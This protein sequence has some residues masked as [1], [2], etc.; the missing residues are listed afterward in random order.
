M[1]L[2][3]VDF[4]SKRIGLATGETTSRLTTPLKTIQASG[5]LQKDAEKIKSISETQQ[6]D[7]IVVGV[8]YA[9]DGTIGAQA[10]I[11]LLLVE[12]LQHLGLPVYTVDETLSSIEA[13]EASK[14]IGLRRATRRKIR[15]TESARIILERFFNEHQKI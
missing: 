3:G 11:C 5:S 2:L 4:G 14:E 7:F 9:L 13:E 8:P 1:R 15:D 10:K 12:K 6:T